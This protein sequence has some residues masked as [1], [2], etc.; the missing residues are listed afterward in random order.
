MAQQVNAQAMAENLARMKVAIAK[1]REEWGGLDNKLAG[2]FGVGADPAQALHYADI[3]EQS[4]ARFARAAQS[5]GPGD[6]SKARSW[7]NGVEGAAKNLEEHAGEAGRVGLLDVLLQTAS[8]TAEDV[9][10]TAATAGKVAAWVSENLVTVLVL[11]A[12]VLWLFKR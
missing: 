11:G 5:I 1:V 6:V 2:I 10:D 7:M 3:A 9:K 8:A 12:V 4:M